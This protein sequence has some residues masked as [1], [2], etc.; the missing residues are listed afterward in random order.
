MVVRDVVDSFV[1]ARTCLFAGRG[2]VKEAEVFGLYEAL[3]WLSSLN[4][5]QVIFEMDAKV[6]VEAV[7]TYAYD[8]TE[9]GSVVQQYRE[10]LARSK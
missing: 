1:I 8:I 7:K 6:V 5:S 3:L 10:L 2:S 4:V 9:F